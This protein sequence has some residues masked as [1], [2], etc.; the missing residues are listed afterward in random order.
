VTKSVEVNNKYRKLVLGI[1]QVLD[2]VTLTRSHVM[3]TSLSMILQLT[4]LV[5]FERTASR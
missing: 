2:H 3:Q 1:W 4:A 5:S